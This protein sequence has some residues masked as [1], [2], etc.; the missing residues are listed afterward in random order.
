MMPD[1]KVFGWGLTMTRFNP[2]PR[3]SWQIPG[4][5]WLFAFEQ[6]TLTYNI[7][8]YCSVAIRIFLF[9]DWQDGSVSCA[10]LVKF[11]AKSAEEKKLANFN[12]PRKRPRSSSS[13]ANEENVARKRFYQDVNALLL[14]E[15]AGDNS[16]ANWQ[17][18]LTQVK[19]DDLCWALDDFHLPAHSVR[20]LNTDFTEAG[21]K[22]T[23]IA[24]IELRTIFAY[25]RT[26]C[27][28]S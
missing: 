16:L 15:T 22:Q 20:H 26:S 10:E 3:H 12:S 27:H 21:R 11:I 7:S 6:N 24:L 17:R 19:P 1:L 4:A 2:T 8:N 9:S 25:V 14:G 13:S 18:I 28:L 5:W 23:V